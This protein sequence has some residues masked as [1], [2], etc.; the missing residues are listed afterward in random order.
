M[1][2]PGTDLR[3]GLC[4]NTSYME[5]QPGIYF[6]DYFIQLFLRPERE[7]V[8]YGVSE[9]A[10]WRLNPWPTHRLARGLC[11]ANGSSPCVVDASDSVPI[12]SSIRILFVADYDARVEERGTKRP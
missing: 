1:R 2:S 11:F 9:R 4:Q 5:R 3:P 8:K 12:V 10:T 6:L 7:A